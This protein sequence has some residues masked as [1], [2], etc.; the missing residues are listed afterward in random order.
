MNVLDAAHAAAH[1]YEGGC[2]SLAPR[3]SMSSALLRNKVNPRS[4]TNHLTLNEAVRL[5]VVT[6]DPRVVQAFAREMGMVCVEM[7]EPDQCGDADVVEMMARSLQTHGEIGRAITETFA[8][9]KVELHEARNVEERVW[10]HMIIALGLAA[11]IKS[12]A[13][14]E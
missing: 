2:E 6:G 3:L 4:S 13:E 1:D 7:P 8:D 5:S 12:M 14:P 9:G 10:A 11:Y